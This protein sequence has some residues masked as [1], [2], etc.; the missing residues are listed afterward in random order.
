MA[1]KV[2][3]RN[4]KERGW[5]REHRQTSYPHHADDVNEDDDDAVA[6]ENELCF[7]GEGEQPMDLS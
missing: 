5:T 6:E 1:M 4:N 3:R 2:D 7:P